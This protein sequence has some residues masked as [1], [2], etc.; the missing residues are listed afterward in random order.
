MMGENSTPVVHTKT[1]RNF[2]KKEKKEKNGKN[3][4]KRWKL[5]KS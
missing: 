4:P 1:N 5:H 2:K 3:L